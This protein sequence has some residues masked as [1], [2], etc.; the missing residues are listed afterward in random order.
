MTDHQDLSKTDKAEKF[1]A[2]VDAMLAA[3]RK[4]KENME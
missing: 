2:A 3:L 1:W 4:V